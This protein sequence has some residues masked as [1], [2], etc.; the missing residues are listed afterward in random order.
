M[1]AP[2]Y[3]N[4]CPEDFEFFKILKMREKNVIK[5]ANF[6]CYRFILYKENI[7]TDR[8]TIRRWARSTLKV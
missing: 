3:K 6:F 8:A 7:L 2:N 5:S 1:D 4:V